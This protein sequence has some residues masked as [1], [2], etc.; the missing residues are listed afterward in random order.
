MNSFSYPDVDGVAFSYAREL[1]KKF[2]FVDI[3]NLTDT[4]KNNTIS[5]DAVEFHDSAEFR[6]E[7]EAANIDSSISI[8][9]RSFRSHSQAPR[10][11]YVLKFAQFKRIPDIVIWPKCHREVVTIVKLAN[12]H[13]VVIIPAGGLSNVT[14][15]NN[16][17]EG[18][19]RTIV[20]LDLTQMNRM[21]WLDKKSMI[22]CFEVG[23]AG[24]DLERTLEERGFV[25]GHEPDSVEFSTLGGWIATRSSG[26]KQQVYGNIEDIIVS[27]K[28]VTSIGVLEKSFIAP[29]VSMGPE[30]EQ[31]V[32]GSEGM[33]GVITEAVVRIHDL[34][35]VRQYGSFVF[36][37]LLSGIDFLRECSRRKV[38]PSS[39][40]L[41]DNFHV[42]FGLALRF[43]SSCFGE[44]VDRMK[45]AALTSIMG[46]DEYSYSMAT[47][48]VEGEKN[49]VDRQEDSLITVAKKHGGIQSGAKYG[50]RGYLMTFTVGY[51]RVSKF[52]I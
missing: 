30:L 40:R 18:E 50:K 17:P 1:F 7:I 13:N 12:K 25:M 3:A 23:V 21:L 41:L 42:Q 34:P 6:L 28:F 31:I 49:S 46:F 16:C 29:R 51:S 24:Q 20:C 33:L 19:T 11:F 45:K 32:L 44:L 27:T 38:V 52:K 15:A 22:A 26:I 39:L 43:N 37:N 2:F 8:D 14:C 47:Y 5:E 36:P 9:D 48:L 10:D 4:P 35:E